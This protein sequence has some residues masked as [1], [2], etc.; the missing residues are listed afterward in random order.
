[1]CKIDKN[2]S[3]NGFYIFIFVIL[4]GTFFFYFIVKRKFKVSRNFL[5][6][7]K[8]RFGVFLGF[9]YIGRIEIDLE[10]VGVFLF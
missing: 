3:R 4:C 9:C 2:F 10:E 6:L 8:D 5:I 1:M 7:D